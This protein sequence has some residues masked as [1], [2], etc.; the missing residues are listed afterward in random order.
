MIYEKRISVQIEPSL[1]QLCTPGLE[2]PT[3]PIVMA[4]GPST[5][6]LG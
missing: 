6:Y 3:A 4:E 5:L 2:E 1:R